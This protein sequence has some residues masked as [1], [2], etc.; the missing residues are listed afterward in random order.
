[1]SSFL[2]IAIGLLTKSKYYLDGDSVVCSDLLGLVPKR[3]RL[4]DIERFNVI[5]KP[6]PATSYLN[7]IL[8]L[9]L[10]DKRFKRIKQIKIQLRNQKKE[11]IDGHFL[12][13]DAFIDLVKRIK[14]AKANSQ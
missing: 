2:Y 5:D 7:N 4:I 1:M 8:W 12:T 14:K 10:Q 9:F 13:E 6:F 3:I 11:R